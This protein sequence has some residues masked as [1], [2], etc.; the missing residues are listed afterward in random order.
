MAFNHV[1]D[2][3]EAATGLSR[4]ESRGTVRLSLK[5]AGLDARSV[6]ADEMSVVLDKLM[7]EEL[8]SRGVPEADEVCVQLI[9]GLAQLGPENSVEGARDVFKR[10][11]S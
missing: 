2:A 7:A 3:L 11:G 1:C 4:L 9:V 8:T 6:S 10:L 5:K